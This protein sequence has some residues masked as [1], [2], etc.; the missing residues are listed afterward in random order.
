MNLTKK[1]RI[2]EFNNNDGRFNRLTCIMQIYHE[3]KDDSPMGLSVNYTNNLKSEEESFR[4]FMT[5]NSEWRELDHG[6]ID[7]ASLVIIENTHP[8]NK[9]NV[10]CRIPVSNDFIIKPKSF[11]VF[12]PT[13]L[14]NIKLNTSN[15]ECKIKITIIPN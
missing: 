3:K 7:E 11:M 14:K 8:L 13:D 4:R 1:P 15:G 10:S 6:W 2:P 9:I 5:L 12:N